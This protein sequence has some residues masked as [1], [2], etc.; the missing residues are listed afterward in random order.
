MDDTL[1]LLVSAEIYRAFLV[2]VRVAAAVAFLPGLGEMVVPVRVRLAVAGVAAL[3]L[4]PAVPGLPSAMPD[5]GTVLEQFAGEML[6]GCFIGLGARL[7]LAALQVSG[8][9]IGLTIGLSNPFAVQGAGFEGG[10]VV[11][12]GLV[13]GALAF[14]F[15][16]DVHYLMLEAVARSYAAWPAAHQ[17]EVGALA[18]DF[19][20]LVAATFRLGVGLAAPF[21]VYA[22]LFNTALG[23]IN[24]VMPA[25][26]VFFVGTPVQLAAGLFAL[27]MAMGAMM[28]GFTAALSTWLAGP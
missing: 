27:A 15:A 24:R 2:F 10:S 14:I 21:L 18:R 22:V 6:V 11:S 26:P 13:M 1:A 3:S 17:P 8:S 20:H 19:S 4:A 25:M 12:G 23:L 7:F 16:T 9:I 28:A 5:G